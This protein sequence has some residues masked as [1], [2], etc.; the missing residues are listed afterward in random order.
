MDDLTLTTTTHVQARRMLT[1]LTDVVSW[2]RIRFKEVKS[3]S[4]IFK[5]VQLTKWFNLQVQN[6]DIPSMVTSQIKCMD[7]RFSAT[8][9]DR[10]NDRKLEQQVEDGLPGKFKAWLYQY[11]LLPRLIWPLMLY[12]V[13]NTTVEALVRNTSRHLR[14]WL[15]VPPSF[16]SIGLYGQTIKPQ[17]PLS[18]LV[19]FKIAKTR[20]VLTLRDS[21]SERI[22]P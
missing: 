18:S 17:V 20:L 15:G 19:E 8:L 4:F 11:A 13:P 12:K 14:K 1:A 10:Y 2:G 7:K 9:H 21:F 3:R 6:E 5:K 16:T 22:H